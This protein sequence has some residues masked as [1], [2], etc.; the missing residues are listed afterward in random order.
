[1]NEIIN[2]DFRVGTICKLKQK[3]KYD[4]Y[5]LI[6]NKQ[7]DSIYHTFGLS[8]IR[9]FDYGK[10]GKKEI[11]D[12]FEFFFVNNTLITR[13]NFELECVGY[14][15]NLK[16]IISLDKIRN[17]KSLEAKNMLKTLEAQKKSMRKE[18][19]I[20]RT[21]NLHVTLLKNFQKTTLTSETKNKRSELL[22]RINYIEL[23]IL[24]LIE[25]INYENHVNPMHELKEKQEIK[26]ISD[27]N[28]N[29]KV[30]ERLNEIEKSINQLNLPKSININSQNDDLIQE[31]QNTSQNS[32]ISTKK[33]NEL[34]I[35]K[36]KL[37][38]WGYINKITIEKNDILS[39][40]INDRIIDEIII[41]DNNINTKIGKNVSL[42]ERNQTIVKEIKQIYNDTCQFCGE[43]IEIGL[44]EYFSNACH[45]RPLEHNGD[46]TIYNLIVLCPNHHVMFDSG[47][48]TINIENKT[49]IHV[50]PQ[51]MINNKE[52][53]LKHDIGKKY[54]EYH[55]EH[56]F[57]KNLTNM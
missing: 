55:N 25:K 7:S 20:I 34:E 15:G 23:L 19:E 21:T 6:I 29:T 57:K 45:I 49:V 16:G 41:N 35:T 37:L 36:A 3:D 31:I 5:V 52:I 22:K 2:Q 39:P 26:K 10:Y 50:N 53:C 33:N 44:N 56:I 11:D 28:I 18:L 43:Q 38:E 8:Q 12:F 1:M 51:H 30:K 47:M 24:I 17:L 4:G 48:I 9:K 42:Y 46:D 27:F 40:S 54:I 13:E 14:I 32:Q